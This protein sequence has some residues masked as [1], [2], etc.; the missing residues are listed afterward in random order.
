MWLHELLN[1][2]A[3]FFKIASDT[4]HLTVINKII[5]TK[6]YA[7]SDHLTVINKIIVT[8]NY[9]CST[10]MIVVLLLAVRFIVVVG[11]Y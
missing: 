7:C 5:V 3:S 4:D 6:N 10:L 11:Y 1:C 8:K 2:F 9:A